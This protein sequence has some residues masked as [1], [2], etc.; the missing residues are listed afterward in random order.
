M[1]LNQNRLLR[2]MD[3]CGFDA[4]IGTAAENVT[5]LSG[6]WALPQW[7]RPGPQAYALQSRKGDAV[8]MSSIITSSG[9]LDL[10]ADQDVT[11]ER[12]RRYGEFSFQ[13]GSN[14]KL[15]RASRKLMAMQAGTCFAHPIEALAA[16]IKELS[17]ER[18]RI[19][20]DID[21]LQPGYLEKLK[22]SVPD[23][24]FVDATSTLRKVRT[25]KTSE[26][27]ARLRR[28][29]QIAEQAVDAALGAAH[30]G[31]TEVE[32][33]RVFHTT[34][35]QADAV[36]VLG[37][38]GF[39]ERSA[40]MNVQP[41]DRELRQGDVIRFDVGG[42]YKHYRA[43]IARIAMFGQNSEA[44]NQLYAALRSGVELGA[45][46]AR[47]G[48]KASEVF[49]SVCEEV[50]R[51]GIA[52][53]QRNHVGHGIGLDGY[54][55]PLLSASSKDVLEEGMVICIETPYY[56]IGAY[57]LQVEDMFVITAEGA[58]RLT[59]AGPLKVIAP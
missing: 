4:I 32:M 43:D 26:E 33:A 7:I 47:P 58:E 49:L 34:T 35:V 57:G 50:R 18:S 5:Y 1:L 21:G 2:E 24:H 13:A 27:I 15:D 59:D 12:V 39:G 17:L 28:V 42:R 19:G 37:C 53:Y 9:T 56:Q 30:A 48:A 41:S 20:I 45:R 14:D 51:C 44:V 25:V 36:P 55:A 10:V 46:L 52:N 6:F 8:D 54:D 16:E 3:H 38:I 29:G 22:A 11:V 31:M 40:L 23:A